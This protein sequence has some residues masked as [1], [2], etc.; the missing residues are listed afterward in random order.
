M[1]YLQLMSSRQGAMATLKVLA[2]CIVGIT[3][4]VFDGCSKKE[5]SP[6][7]PSGPAPLAVTG[8]SPSNNA[9]GVSVN[10]SITAT[11]SRELNAATVT[12]TS[13]YINGVAGSALASGSTATFTP[14]S[15]L[16]EATAYTV[17]VT[18]GVEDVNGVSMDGEYTSSF[19]TGIVALANAG[20]DRDASL[21]ENVNLSGSSSVGGS[22]TYVWAQVAGPSVGSLTGQS[23]A[24]TAPDTVS[25]LIFTLRVDNGSG[26]S[27]PDTVVVWVLEDRMNTYWVSPSGSD[28]NAGTRIAPLLTIETAIDRA[29]TDGNDGDVYIAAGSYA[30]SISLVPN[31]SLYGGYDPQ[32]WL[33]GISTNPTTIN[34]G[35]LAVAGVEAHNVVLDGLRIYSADAAL[36]G[37]SSIAVSFARSQGIVIAHNLI[38][39]GNGAAG[40]NGAQPGKP[41]KASTGGGG[42]DAG[43]C[44]PANEGGSGAGASGRRG[45]NGGSGGAAGGFDGGGGEGPCGDGANGGF[46]SGGS[47][48]K[49]GCGSGVGS[50]SDIPGEGFGSI[51][52]GLYFGGNGHAGAKGPNGGGGG[53][54]GG[55]SGSL[56]G[57][58]AGG[59]GGGEGGLGGGGGTSGLGGGASIGIV[60]SDNS[61]ATL[62]DNTVSTGNGG[63]G[64]YGG[65]GAVGGD[66]GNGGSG[67][68]SNSAGWGGGNGGNGGAGGTGGV[69][70]G[71][72]GGPSVGIVEQGSSSFQDRVIF[73]F[74]TPG[75]GGVRPDAKGIPGLQGEQA[76][77]KKVS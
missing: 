6:N 19:T 5:G 23:P 16:A 63:D 25:T 10:A 35:A 50:D 8:I 14:S 65:A 11:F 53:G 68:G 52:S 9:T 42:D 22:I 48:G 75:Q 36:P 62:V 56:I 7:G 34:G 3:L 73:N 67:G 45:G 77:V 29:F 43:S 30:G 69:G 58:G 72:G 64:G 41:A 15:P 54:G 46:A 12:A 47:R 31:V 28:A 57:C 59:G 49:D 33:R 74:G 61:E 32:T 4:A 26:P 70:S 76:E 44:I 18:S 21:G 55:G 13:F 17:T 2:V 27:T 24:F 66:G 51:I 60:L 1:L 38:V 39:A 20:P 71:G 40:M 37:Q